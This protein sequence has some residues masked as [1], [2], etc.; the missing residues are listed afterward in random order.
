M[1]EGSCGAARPRGRC[2][3]FRARPGRR[4]CY[5]LARY[6]H[7]NAWRGLLCQ[8]FPNC[9][10]DQSF[11]D[12]VVLCNSAELP[13]GGIG[14][15]P[16]GVKGPLAIS[17]LPQNN[18]RLHGDPARQINTSAHKFLLHGRGERYF[19]VARRTDR[20]H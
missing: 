6:Q 13:S 3:G 7:D 12:L 18:K 20:N 8:N 16:G 4:L 10:I 2:I 5:R 17:R 15:G 19:A 1:S 14:Q 11:W 9:N